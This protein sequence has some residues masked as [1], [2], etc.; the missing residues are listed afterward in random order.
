MLKKIMK[1]SLIIRGRR[2]KE[3]KDRREGGGEEEETER[4]KRRVD[5]IFYNNYLLS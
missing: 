1:C 3:G 5:D 2:T 4:K